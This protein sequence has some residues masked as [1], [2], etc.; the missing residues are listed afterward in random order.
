M[1]DDFLA[2]GYLSDGRLIRP[3]EYSVLSKNAYYFVVP[4]GPI[5]HPAVAAFRNWLVQGFKT[6]R[7]VKRTAHYEN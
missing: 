5:Q 7:I 2:D 4:D 3:F 6:K 1:G